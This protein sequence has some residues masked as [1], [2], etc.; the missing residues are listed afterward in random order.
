M[1]DPTRDAVEAA[2]KGAREGVRIAEEVV[3]EEIALVFTKDA[4]DHMEAEIIK[5]F[6]LPSEPR[7]F[8]RSD[9]KVFRLRKDREWEVQSEDGRW[10][11]WSLAKE[12]PDSMNGAADARG[13]LALWD[14]TE[15]DK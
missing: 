10:C 9:G 2:R 4:R 8:T 11:F 6:P 15:E 1:S 14:E 3:G 5:R 7:T 13:L 12:W